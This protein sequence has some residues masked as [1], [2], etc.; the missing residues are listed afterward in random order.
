MAGGD[1]GGQSGLKTNSD[2][3]YGGPAHGEASPWRAFPRT[4]QSCGRYRASASFNA[5]ALDI[6]PRT[7]PVRTNNWTW[8]G[9]SL[10]QMRAEVE[11]R[12]FTTQRSDCR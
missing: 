11:L 2:A 9:P 3:V 5:L 12:D 10:E 1:R 4:P 7:S 8:A 6:P